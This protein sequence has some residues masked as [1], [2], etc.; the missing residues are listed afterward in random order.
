M[1]LKP[2]NYLIFDE[3][4]GSLI[5]RRRAEDLSL[6]PKAIVKHATPIPPDD[7]TWRVQEVNGN[8]CNLAI[9]NSP[10]TSPIDDLVWAI[11]KKGDPIPE[12]WNIEPVAGKPNRYIILT[13]DKRSAWDV[14]ELNE[15]AQ[16]KCLP[17]GVKAS[18]FQFVYM[19]PEN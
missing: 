5:G 17:L 12:G 10:Y 1:P 15:D 14:P 9:G 16:I 6:N 2:G 7:A 19:G 3:K 8:T 13:N 4:S 18:V 11:L